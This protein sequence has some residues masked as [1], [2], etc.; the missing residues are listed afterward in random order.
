MRSVSRSGL[1]AVAREDLLVAIEVDLQRA[2]WSV[3]LLPEAAQPRP[4]L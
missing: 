3:M 4:W 1:K 2:G